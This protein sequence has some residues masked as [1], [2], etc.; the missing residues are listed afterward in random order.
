MAE[1]LDAAGF[2]D[3]SLRAA[4]AAAAQKEP[5]SGNLVGA[6][7]RDRG[8]ALARDGAKPSALDALR[9]ARA[10]LRPS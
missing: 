2:R 9:E 8:W 7:L 4:R 6:L 10:S 3:T 5:G 1:A